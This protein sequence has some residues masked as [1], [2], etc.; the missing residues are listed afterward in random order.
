[1]EP[2]KK[3]YNIEAEC[4]IQSKMRRSEGGNTTW[5]V[6][7]GP[8][9]EEEKDKEKNMKNSVNQKVE[10]MNENSTFGFDILYLPIAIRE[11]M[12]KSLITPT[13]ISENS[14]FLKKSINDFSFTPELLTR[15]NARTT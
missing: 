7:G 9:E 1:M 8:D 2:E 15:K 10:T 4:Q 12:S 11:S 6:T 14:E 5:G 3:S 13:K